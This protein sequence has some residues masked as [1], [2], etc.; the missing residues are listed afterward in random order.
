VG[1]GPF[2]PYPGFAT[3]SGPS[4]GTKVPEPTRPRRRDRK[5]PDLPRPDRSASAHTFDPAAATT[6]L[7]RE[8]E[9]RDEAGFS[10]SSPVGCRNRRK[11]R[12][13]YGRPGGCGRTLRRPAC[14]RPPC[15]PPPVTTFLLIAGVVA[16][17]LAYAASRRPLATLIAVCALGAGGHLGMLSAPAVVASPITQARDALRA[18]QAAQSAKLICDVAQSEALSRGSAADDA[19]ATRDCPAS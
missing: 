2:S 16:L 10:G 11:A 1:R 7:P 13:P 9:P 8:V 15:P 6:P 3:V 18:W 17:T 12:Q 4:N 14:P 5:E 19:Q